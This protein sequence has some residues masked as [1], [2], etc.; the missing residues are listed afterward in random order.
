LDD[1][2]QLTDRQK[3]LPTKITMKLL[4]LLRSWVLLVFFAN[5]GGAFKVQGSRREFVK[6]L[7][8]SSSIVGAAALSFGSQAEAKGSRRVKNAPIETLENGIKYQEMA[9][10]DGPSPKKGDRCAI[11]YS[12]YYNGMEVE[13]SRDS[14]G[15][16]ATP[17]GFNMG[18]RFNRNVPKSLQDAIYG[19]QV[20]GRRKVTIPGEL[21]YGE[22]GYP[23]FIP[24]N[25]EVMFDIS[26]WSVK[27][28]GSN[29]NL[30]LPGQSN[31]F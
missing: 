1:Y 6:E 29:P 8:K 4:A 23:P 7:V 27:P 31:Y 19:M 11:H 24:K 9:I 20:G 10:G 18:E 5:L 22:A 12:I 30:T 21:A 17:L 3:D 14:S 28:A 13:S 2:I 15:L 26:L 16:A 25:A